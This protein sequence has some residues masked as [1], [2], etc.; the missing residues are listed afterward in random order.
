MKKRPRQKKLPGMADVSIQ[1]IDDAAAAFVDVRDNRMALTR[2]EVEAS[3]KLLEV[4]RKH[5]LTTYSYDGKTV[6]ITSQQKVKV[7]R[8]DEAED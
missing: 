6:S 4:M 3:E 8:N 7:K 2:E 5:K 1:E